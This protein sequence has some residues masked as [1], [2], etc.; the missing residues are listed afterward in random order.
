LFERRFA[1][2]PTQNSL[3]EEIAGTLQNRLMTVVQ[4]DDAAAATVTGTLA[5]S[6]GAGAT[7]GSINSMSIESGRTMMRAT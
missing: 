1:F 5:A 6:E 7:V 2:G 4:V 3:M